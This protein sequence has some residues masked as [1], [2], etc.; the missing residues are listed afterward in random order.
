M[1]GS[2]YYVS[3]YGLLASFDIA[4]REWRPL[5]SI[6]WDMPLGRRESYFLEYGGRLT[7]AFMKTGSEVSRPEC[8]IFRFG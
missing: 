7:I 5:V 2:F 1:E 3:K 4:T 8:D 6:M